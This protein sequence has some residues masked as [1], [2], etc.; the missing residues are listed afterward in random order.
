MKTR[1]PNS[2]LISSMIGEGRLYAPYKGYFQH[3]GK[4]LSGEHRVKEYKALIEWCERAISFMNTDS[5]D[6]E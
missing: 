5:K 2:K 6:G 3:K 1:Q 4:Y